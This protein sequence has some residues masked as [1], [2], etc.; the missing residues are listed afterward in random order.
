MSPKAS[1]PS[2]PHHQPNKRQPS[3]NPRIEKGDPIEPEE[4]AKAGAAPED[5]RIKITTTPTNL[6]ISSVTSTE[7]TQ[8]TQPIIALKRIKL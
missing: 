6:T 3:I 1:D 4:E 7:E 5:L 8:T 2:S